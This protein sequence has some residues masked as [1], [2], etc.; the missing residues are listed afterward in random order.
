MKTI[1]TA[2]Q[3]TNG[4]INSFTRDTVEGWW[5]VEVGLPKTW[6]YDEN[7]KIGCEIIFENEVGKLIKIFPKEHDVVIDDLMAFVE[8]IIKTNEKIAEKEKQFTDK[9]KEMRG[10]L[11]KEAKHFYKELDEIKENS[12]KTLN[13]TFTKNL[14]QK[15]PT[16]KPTTVR[17]SPTEKPNTPRKPRAPRTPKTKT[18]QTATKKTTKTVTEETET[19]DSSKNSK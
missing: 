4:Y 6:V 14:N 9:M 16:K 12:F 2:L 15:K 5:E 11:E 7:K 19:L 13:D 17:I 3:P 10:L 8:I 18:G 1:E